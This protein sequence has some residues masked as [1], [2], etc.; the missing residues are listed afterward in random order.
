MGHQGRGPGAGRAPVAS[1]AGTALGRIRDAMRAI[2]EP[3][4]TPEPAEPPLSATQVLVALTLLR[5]LR[6]EIAGWEPDLI[7]AARRLGTSWAELAPALG[8]AG[9]QAAE[10]R[11]LRLRPTPDGS[12]AT[13]DQRVA[14]ERDRRAG[15]RAVA[16]WARSNAAGL[17]QLAGQIGA[18]PDLP[19]GAEADLAALRR[20]LG[21]DDAAAL[22]GPLAEVRGHLQPDHPA[23]AERVGAVGRSTTEVRR[24]SD[25]RRRATQL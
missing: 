12:T 24:A 22:L 9:R 16:G 3:E 5:E 21:R 7:E 23:L 6:V 20:A 15:D 25:R 18:L 14:A 1:D 4:R 2:H 17:R 8:V 19:A 10:R 11:Y 13:G